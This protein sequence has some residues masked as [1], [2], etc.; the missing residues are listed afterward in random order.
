MQNQYNSPGGKKKKSHL[1]VAHVGAHVLQAAGR[2]GRKQRDHDWYRH[3]AAPPA[4]TNK[5]EITAFS[6]CRT[7]KESCCGVSSYSSSIIF[8]SANSSRV[9]CRTLKQNV[10]QLSHLWIFFLHKGLTKIFSSIVRHVCVR[11]IQALSSLF[12]S[13]CAVLNCPQA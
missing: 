11:H 10:P 3:V 6:T 4:L 12:C 5:S 9:L 2:C 1:D 7:L 13:F 8:R